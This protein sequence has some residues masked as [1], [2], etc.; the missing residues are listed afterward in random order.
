MPA[1]AM[2]SRTHISCRVNPRIAAQ[3]DD[4]HC[5]NAERD[6]SGL[7]QSRVQCFLFYLCI[8]Y[9]TGCPQQIILIVVV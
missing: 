5:K 3:R 7:D 9:P 2:F 6:S 4:K 1:F 8:P